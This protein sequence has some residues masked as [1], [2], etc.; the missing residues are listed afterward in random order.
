MQSGL[1][2]LT[3]GEVAKAAGVSTAL[4]H[5]HFDTK[6]ALLIAV[7]EAVATS[8]VES[9]AQALAHGRGLETVDRVWERA[10][11]GAADGDGRLLAELS[12]RATR[13]AN[14]AAA[15]GRRMAASRSALAARL[16]ELARELGASL[17]VPVDEAAAALA[18]LLDG[19]VLAMVAG[20]TVPDVRTAY[21]AFWLTLIAAGQGAR[22]R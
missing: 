12:S 2:D 18:A 11:A 10:Q 6:Q 5:Y 3:V 13:D 16:P 19:L 21:D 20:S 8:A 17:A 22:R 9:L 14:I 7:A 1:A 4:V 15:V